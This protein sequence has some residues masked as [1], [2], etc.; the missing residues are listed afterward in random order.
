M[1]NCIKCNNTLINPFKLNSLKYKICY[2]C[3]S[4]YKL[5]NI[6]ICEHNKSNIYCKECQD[7]Y[8]CLND[9]IKKYKIIKVDVLTKK[10]NI[11]NKNNCKH[12][13]YK[14][15]CK[16]C[17]SS[18]ICK[19]KKLKYFCIDCKGSSICKHDKLKYFCIDCKGS[20]IYKHKKRKYIYS[21]KAICK[22]FI[23]KYYCKE[24]KKYKNV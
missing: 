15:K 9:K 13:S 3:L 23:R 5:Q 7:L 8:I 17:K 20:S 6:N 19:H 12:G 10:T 1:I 14:Y 11:I 16:I 18:S 21:S 4:N 24:C 22:H 2:N